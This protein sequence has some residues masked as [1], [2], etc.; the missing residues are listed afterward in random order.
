MTERRSQSSTEAPMEALTNQRIDA[1]L[2]NLH[3]IA[4][5][6]DHK[7]YGLPMHEFG[8]LPKFRAAVVRALSVIEPRKTPEARIAELDA[9]IVAEIH[10]MNTGTTDEPDPE[11]LA[12]ATRAIEAIDARR[13]AAPAPSAQAEPKCLCGHDWTPGETHICRQSA[14]GG[15][16]VSSPAP[17]A[18]TAPEGV[19]DTRRLDLLSRCGD[20]SA[21]TVPSDP[22]DFEIHLECVPGIPGEDHRFT[23]EDLRECIDAAL[24]AQSTPKEPTHG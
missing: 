4:V 6:Y 22:H 11:L 19:T 8:M 21:N 7:Y 23:G 20:F 12:A 5:E 10:K 9:L 24:A 14:I 3:D 13:T 17:A 1:L 16:R 15:K 2:S 18:L